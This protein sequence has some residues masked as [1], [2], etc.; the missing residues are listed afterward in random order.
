MIDNTTLH[1]ASTNGGSKY[2]DIVDKHHIKIT[3]IP[4]ITSLNTSCF[5]SIVS[6]HQSLLPQY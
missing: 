1:G 6:E 2:Y 3:D 5:S 4:L